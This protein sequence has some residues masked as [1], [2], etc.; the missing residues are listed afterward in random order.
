MT[1]SARFQKGIRRWAASAAAMALALAGPAGADGLSVIGFDDAVHHWQLKRGSDYPRHDESDVRAIAD[2]LLLMQR[3]HGGWVQNRDPLQV[4][5]AG[6]VKQL[7]AEKGET[8]GSFDNRNVFTQIEYLMGAFVLTGEQ[9]YREAATRGLDYLLRNQFE[10][11]GGWPHSVPAQAA[12][13][14]RLTV[15]DEVFSGPLTLLRRI[16]EARAPFD[17]FDAETRATAKAALAR[18][19]DC[20]LRLQVRQGDTLTGWAGQYDPMTLAPMGGRTFELTAI[21]SQET[22]AILDYLMSIESP[23]PEV[24]ASVAGAAEWLRAVQ[25]EG[26]RLETVPLQSEQAYRYHN[27][28]FDRQLVADPGAR[29]LWARFYD[30]ADNTP[31]L[32]NRDGMRVER[33]DQIDPERRTG[34][35]WY[36]NWASTLLD[37]DFPAW[38]C[39]VLGTTSEGAPCT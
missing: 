30:I 39:R 26:W 22:V 28:K 23:S 14:S 7:L 11:C 20:L 6:D 12:Y 8:Q 9:Q 15:A 18:G 13:Q 10:T 17:A 2:N 5:S 25:I 3:N 24:I 1:G 31:V 37:R 16:S 21:V 35:S 4:M 29:P 38:R 33:F 27:A 34:Y 32:A 19:E 36:G